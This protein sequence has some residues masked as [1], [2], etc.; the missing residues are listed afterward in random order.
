MTERQRFY[1]V[2]IMMLAMLAVSAFCSI[3]L[4]RSA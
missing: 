2:A 1:V 3:V 4:V